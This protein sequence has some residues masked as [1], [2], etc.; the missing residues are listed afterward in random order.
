MLADLP[1]A[2]IRLPRG[3]L[4]RGPA[5]RRLGPPEQSVLGCCGWGRGPQGS[6]DRGPGGHQSA[7]WISH[8]PQHVLGPW[9]TQSSHCPHNGHSSS[10]GPGSAAKLSIRQPNPGRPLSLS[11][12]LALPTGL[13]SAQLRLC[14]PICC[15]KAQNLLGGGHSA[16]LWV[17]AIPVSFS[18]ALGDRADLTPHPHKHT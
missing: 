2:G 9:R 3:R 15:P 12:A 6:R 8:Y 5:F 13:P 1:R 4:G 14:L 10:H 17:F 18:A 16:S 7:V 11:P